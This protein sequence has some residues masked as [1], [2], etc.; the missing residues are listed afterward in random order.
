MIFSPKSGRERNSFLRSSRR[1]L[2]WQHFLEKRSSRL[3]KQ[4]TFHA[5]GNEAD[6]FFLFTKF[7]ISSFSSSVRVQLLSSSAEQRS[8]S[9]G[10]CVSVNQWC[11]IS[12]LLFSQGRSRV[13][14]RSRVIPL[15]GQRQCTCFLGHGTRRRHR[16]GLVI[17]A[18]RRALFS[19]ALS[20]GDTWPLKRGES[21]SFPLTTGNKPFPP[22][23]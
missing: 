8:E 11:A 6:S 2:A 20:F 22:R 17:S 14:G 15:A 1:I 16:R 10:P 19:V 5:S 4:K 13:V 3:T 23:R 7:K 9:R 21:S 18:K 12:L